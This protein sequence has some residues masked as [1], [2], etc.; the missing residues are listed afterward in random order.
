MVV[1][2]KGTDSIVREKEKGIILFFFFLPPFKP[3][4]N[5][6]EIIDPFM[7]VMAHFTFILCVHFGR[8]YL[9]MRCIKIRFNLKEM[10]RR[11]TL[12]KDGRGETVRG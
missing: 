1:S 10:E 3:E 12:G 8:S 11:D 2:R 5:Y 7:I 6:S 9:G 4:L